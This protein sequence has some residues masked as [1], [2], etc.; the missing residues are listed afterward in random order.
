MNVWEKIFYRKNVKY[1][2]KATVKKEMLSNFIFSLFFLTLIF[3]LIR[4]I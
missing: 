1:V 2:N 3:F 4:E